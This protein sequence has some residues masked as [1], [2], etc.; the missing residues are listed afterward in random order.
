[1]ERAKIVVV[2]L[3][4][5]TVPLEL[6]EPMTVSDALL[7]KAL[8]DLLGREHITEAVVLSTCMRTEIYAVA[9]GFHGAMADVRNFLADW[10][11]G[12][13]ET[14]CDYLYSF[15]GDGAISH[16][17]RVAS[18]IDSA[19]LGE[20]EIVRQ[21][22]DAWQLARHEDAAGPTLTRL[23]RHAIEV[24]KRARSETA[25]SRGTTSMSQAA[26][27][28]A[29][30]RLGALQ[31]QTIL[32]VGAGEMGQ[33]I[34]QALASVPGIG[35]I[36]VSNRTWSK[37]AALAKQVGGRPLAFGDVAAAL[38]QTDLLL[39]STG[40]PNLLLAADDLQA[41]LPARRGRPL[42]VVD[43][44]VPRDVDPA[45][46][47]LAGVTLL[48]MDD[49]KA[50]ADAGM[51]QRRQEVGA[52]NQIVAEE[53]ERFVQLTAH[54]EAAPVVAALR[55]RAEQLRQ[56]ELHRHRAR[57]AGLNERQQAVV[58]SVTRGILAKLLHEPT[59][60]L[61]A[62]SGSAHGDQLADAVRTLFGLSVSASIE[63]PSQLGAG[64]DAERH[65]DV[66]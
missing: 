57:L 45:V 21:V 31:G 17:F 47:N 1:M 50:F 11:G 41:V 26:V 44:A 20:G 54:R 19:I 40:A 23:F 3:N 65:E 7:P 42:L 52:V 46:G 34:A 59:V 4:H 48:N 22:R 43:V 36:L 63:S 18:G 14:F 25:I 39:T 24:G 2:G 56:A 32:V 5:R 53:V 60:R 10:S 8:H 58:E 6:L 49:L 15:Y 61:K 12:E 33:G 13:P 62:A 51:A 29:A 35:E 30:A 37:G 38:E 9:E 66:A 28:M 27:S 64:A 55:D 16:L